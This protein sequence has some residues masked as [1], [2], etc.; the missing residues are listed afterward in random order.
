MSQ[1][2]PPQLVRKLSNPVTKSTE[3]Q[4]RFLGF[5]IGEHLNALIPLEDLQATIKISSDRKSVV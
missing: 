1:L 4:Q 5:T 3:E 2:S